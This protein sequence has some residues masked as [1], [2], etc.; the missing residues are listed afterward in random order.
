MERFYKFG[1]HWEVTPQTSEAGQWG[2]G[3]FFALA[4]GQ[5][6][7]QHRDGAEETMW[8]SEGAVPV[9][10]LCLRASEMNRGRGCGAGILVPRAIWRHL[11]ISQSFLIPYW[12]RA[13]NARCS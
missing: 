10:F 7:G 2:L 3:G 9:V 5:G 12:K 8:A 11:Y 1:N 13:P 6:R 4:E